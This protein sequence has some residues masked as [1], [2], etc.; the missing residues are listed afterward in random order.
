MVAGGT[1]PSEMPALLKAASRRPN[2]SSATATMRS[3]SAALATLVATK[4]AAAPR[5]RSS[6]ASASPSSALRSAS[7]RLAPSR[8]NSSAVARPMPVAAPVIRATFAFSSFMV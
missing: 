2:F 3:Q 7:T 4:C 1:G 6:P 8:A 5:A